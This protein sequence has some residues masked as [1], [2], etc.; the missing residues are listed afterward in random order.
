MR[1]FC[2]FFFFEPVVGRVQ[3]TEQDMLAKEAIY[4]TVAQA[5]S[6]LSQYIAPSHVAAAVRADLA[7]DSTGA[8]VTHAPVRRRMA[9]VL[10]T[11]GQ[12]D[13]FGRASDTIAMV[14][15]LLRDPNLIVRLSALVA[16]KSSEIFLWD[17]DIFL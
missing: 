4:A 3:L 15:T 6:D 5:A 8:S 17:S 10:E 1:L 16:L 7:A 13:G 9:G 14:L 11:W 2:F 12:L